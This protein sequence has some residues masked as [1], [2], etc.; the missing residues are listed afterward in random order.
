MKNYDEFA[1]IV[2]READR[3]LVRKRKRAVAVRRYTLAFAGMFAVFLTGIFVIKNETARQ[4]LEKKFNDRYIITDESRITKDPDVTTLPEYIVTS[5]DGAEYYTT[6]SAVSDTDETRETSVRTTS[7][8]KTSETSSASR[9]EAV[10]S[11]SARTSASQHNADITTTPAVST[12]EYA[13][14]ST[15]TKIPVTTFKTTSRRTTQTTSSEI[16]VT[17]SKTFT[18]APPTT[19][20][21]MPDTTPPVT[22]VRPITTTSPPIPTSPVSTTTS[23]TTIITTITTVTSEN[24]THSTT[25]TTITTTLRTTATLQ[26]T[27]TTVTVTAYPD[28]ELPPETADPSG[29]TTVPVTYRYSA[30]LYDVIPGDLIGETLI[31]TGGM[32]YECD[33]YVFSGSDPLDAV[34]LYVRNNDKWLLYESKMLE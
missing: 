21:P 27:Q 29:N 32:P 10:S 3:R 6:A 24:Q 4:A 28:I 12:D 18:A 7:S 23:R 13:K 34:L 17:V 22:T 5:S 8:A 14:T 31:D 25:T 19:T 30:E 16:I 20:K 2:F 26:T 33:V 11:T 15:L 1:E 9:T